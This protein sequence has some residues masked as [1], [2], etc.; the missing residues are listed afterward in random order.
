MNKNKRF[1][2]IQIE[3]FNFMS[4]FVEVKISNPE[5]ILIYF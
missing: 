2:Q 5:W 4:T 1:F 3:N